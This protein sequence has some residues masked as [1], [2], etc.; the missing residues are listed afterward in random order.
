MKTW[1]LLADRTAVLFLGVAA[2]TAIGFAFAGGREPA[3][4]VPPLVPQALA[5]PPPVTPAGPQP[6]T[7][8][9]D[10]AAP[11][12][13]PVSISP[14]APSVPGA[15]EVPPAVASV[16]D[17]AIALPPS[18]ARTVAE[19]RPVRVGVYGDSFG[20]G[21][22]SGLAR[23]LPKKRG[24][25]VTKYSR[26]ATGF[27]R[28]KSLNLESHT[29]QQVASDPVDIAVVSYGANDT[30]GVIAD[31]HLAKYMSPAWQGL[32]ARRAAGLVRELRNSGATVYWVGLP[33]MRKPA[34]DADITAMNAFYAR[35]MS[36]LGVP[37]IDTR[38]MSSGPDGFSAYLPD[39]SG[40]PVLM[41]ADD[42]VHM[43]MNGYVRITR[44]LAQRIDALVAAARARAGLPLAGS[45]VPPRP[46]EPARFD[47]GAPR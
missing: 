37:F 11:G 40:K 45:G 14:D 43:S 22:W 9:A 5:P 2:G 36:E 25:I 16:P 34:F 30:Q 27:T 44:G 15:P 10:P 39:S 3:P 12:T 7:V 20:D 33:R 32:I 26:Q 47:M 21:V 41:R 18:L 38:P 31:G 1:Q 19:G 42:G 24:Y 29:A 4:V 17:S 23:E 13:E 8:E 6:E 35:L 28:Y 46:V